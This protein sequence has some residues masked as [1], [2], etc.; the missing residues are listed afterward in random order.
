MRKII[1][2]ILALSLLLAGCDMGGNSLSQALG[3]GGQSISQAINGKGNA[4]EERE[5]ESSFGENLLEA[6]DSLFGTE[7]TEPATYTEIEYTRPD[8]EQLE[9]VL[10]ES[11]DIALEGKS[12]QDVE[13]AIWTFYD[14]YDWFYT[15]YNLSYIRYCGDLT[16]RYWE[17]EYNFCA[18]N[19]ATVDAGLEELYYALADSPQRNALE[20]RLFGNGYFDSYDGESIWDAEFL[21]LMEQEAALEGEYY[22]VS[23]EAMD[24]EYYSDE[25]FET[26]GQDLAEIFVELVKV[27]QQMA[28]KAGYDSYPEFAY[29]WYYYRDYTPEEAKVYTDRLAVEL[30]DIYTQVNQSNIW[31]VGNRRCSEEDTFAY[32]EN[33]AAVMGGV[34]EEAF[35]TMHEGGYYDIAYGENKSGGSFEV[36]LTSYGVPFLFMSPEKTTYDQL[37]F[38]H[39]FG[40]FVNDYSC[41]GSYAGIDVAEVFSQS[42]EFLS[43][44]YTDGMEDLE[45]YKLADSLCT[46]VEQAAYAAFEHQVYDLTGDQLTAENIFALYEK[47]GLEFGFDSW[48]WDSRDFVIVEHFFTEPLYVISY[49]VSNDVAF[50][51]YQL[52]KEEPGAG[53]ELFMDNVDS[54]ESFIVEFAESIGLESPLGTTRL[55]SV[56]ESMEEMLG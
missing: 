17:E 56:R 16:D 53:L 13:D 24:V 30:Y 25:F 7:E 21:G 50:Q 36:F 47:I 35:Q 44:C 20:R 1:A 48:N 18:D 19:A 29:D 5:K 8:M 51:I 54:E 22:R 9:A 11:C 12:Y 46:Y 45:E 40:H 43:L 34:V 10:Q 2:L 23:A 15:N 37:V 49:V 26:Y 27:R 41:G 55:A 4:E 39:E 3:G 31:S 52:E 38:A 42:M 33:C 32:V 14:E 28:A 6:L